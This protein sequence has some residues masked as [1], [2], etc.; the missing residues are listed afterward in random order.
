MASA[1]AREERGGGG[2]S[3][4]PGVARSPY[5]RSC[6]AHAAT[7]F[8]P[9]ANLWTRASLDVHA[10]HNAGTHGATNVGAH[11]ATNAGAH[12]GPHARGPPPVSFT[13]TWMCVVPTLSA[14][15]QHR[16]KKRAVCLRLR[17]VDRCGRV[18]A[19]ACARRRGAQRGAPPA[20]L[21]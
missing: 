13:H 4:L 6:R 21:V 18:V 3:V 8:A 2:G 17:H 1:G 10:V 9:T 11:G 14:E 15:R 7:P 19:R 5:D 20:D 16:V 12:T